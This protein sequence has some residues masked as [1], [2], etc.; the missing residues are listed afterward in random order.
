MKLFTM[1]DLDKSMK[2]VSVKRAKAK[3][4]TKIQGMKIGELRKKLK[5]TQK[6]VA[7]KLNVSQAAVSKLEHSDD[8]GLISLLSYIYSLGGSVKITALVPDHDEVVLLK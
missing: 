7:K 6:Q 3:A 8:L 4:A 1:E 5:M 2:P